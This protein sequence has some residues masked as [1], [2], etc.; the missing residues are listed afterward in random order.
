MIDENPPKATAGDAAHLVV[1]AGLS[2]IPVVGG[3]AAELFAALIIPPL[4]KRRDEWVQSVVDGLKKLEERIEGFSIDALKDNEAFITV[5]MH[6]TQ[7]V[8]RNHHQ[9]KRDALRSA[10]LNV[11]SGNAPDEDL[12]LMFLNFVDSFA[13]WHLRLLR[14]FQDPKAY[15]AARGIKYPD[16]NMG[17]ISTVVEHTFGELKGLR[18][19]YDQL[20]TDLFARGLVSINSLHTTMTVGGMFT[21]RTTDMGDKFLAFITSPLRD[22]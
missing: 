18:T 13:P 7:A 17:G 19:F 4:A 9:D 10:V 11:A 15:G 12:Q 21:K 1:K 16:W 8:I 20:N 6:A 3:P 14:F 5:V 22:E 2:S